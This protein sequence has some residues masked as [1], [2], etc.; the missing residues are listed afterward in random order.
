[1]DSIKKLGCNEGQHQWLL[2]SCVQQNL[3]ISFCN[4]GAQEE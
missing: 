1:M 2:L 3:L 4:C